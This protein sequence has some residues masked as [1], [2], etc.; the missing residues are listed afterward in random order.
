MS[1]MANQQRDADAGADLVAKDVAAFPLAAFSLRSCISFEVEVID[2]VEFTREVFS[3]SVECPACKE[4]VIRHECDD[5][6]SRP[7]PIDRPPEEP[8]IGIRN[9]VF[10]ASDGTANERFS[11]SCVYDVIL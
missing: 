7:K 1:S 5:S 8:Y 10:V 6:N 2:S 4:P 11:D 9:G 3:K